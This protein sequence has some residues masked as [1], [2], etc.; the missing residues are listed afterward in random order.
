M[1]SRATTEE[2][3]EILVVPIDEGQLEALFHLSRADRLDWKE[4]GNSPSITPPC[5]HNMSSR[6][7]EQGGDSV[8]TAHKIVLTCAERF[9][10]MPRMSYSW[11]CWTAW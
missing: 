8:S 10:G 5:V 3:P 1:Y 11:L 2:G 7:S 4:Y 9:N 6:P